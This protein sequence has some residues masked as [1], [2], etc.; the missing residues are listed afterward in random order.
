MRAATCSAAHASAPPRGRI[1]VVG[2]GVAGVAAALA[3]RRR[4][5]DAVVYEAQRAAN[6]AHAGITL[7]SAALAALRRID[8][9]V[10]EAVIAAG[11]VITTLVLRDLSGRPLAETRVGA[12]DEEPTLCL[13]WTELWRILAD[14][15]PVDA[16]QFGHALEDFTDASAAPQPNSAPVL[17]IFSHRE[18]L[19][20][21][22]VPA[23]ALVGADGV[24]SKV[25]AARG[26]GR[27]SQGPH[28]CRG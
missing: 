2:A 19:G 6:C 10:A 25:R 18:T 9:T 14:A 4:G 12:A 16:L 28:V 17:A 11:D 13:R 27:V 20:Q 23:A 5:Y 15:L 1:A 24:R 26:A 3:L 8:A 21:A 7:S 22:A